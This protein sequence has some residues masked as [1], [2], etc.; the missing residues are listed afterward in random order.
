MKMKK[1]LLLALCMVVSMFALTACGG[2]SDDTAA[3]DESGDVIPIRIAHT[4]AEDRSLNMAALEFEKYVEAE[5]ANA[6]FNVDVQVYPNGSFSGSDADILQAVSLGQIEISYAAASAY[7]NF[8]AQWGILDAPFL[9]DSADEYFAAM[10]GDL[11][12][13]LQETLN[14]ST[15][16]KV[17]GYSFMGV[18]QM[19]NSKHPIKSVDDMAGLKMRTQQSDI[20]IAQYEAMGANSTP[21]SFGEVY[22]ALQQGTC[23]G[24]DQTG[25]II[26]AQK[27]YE[28]QDYMTIMNINYGTMPFTCTNAWWDSLDPALQEIIQAGVDQYILDWQRDYEL[29]AEAEAQAAIAEAGVEVYTPTD[30]ELQTF[31]DACAS[32][33]DEFKGEWG[34]DVFAAAGK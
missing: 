29:N 3:T 26:L 25:T 9:F 31:K 16:F 11:G 34:A 18:K 12:A 24:Q 33:I 17:L 1:A 23:D 30:A 13:Y 2:S 5:A 4:E 22:T 32:V 14:A 27:W 6:G 19:T 28:V 21:M 7:T 20:H 15:D 8:D 10:D